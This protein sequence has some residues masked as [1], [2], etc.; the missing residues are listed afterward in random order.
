MRQRGA[1]GL[2]VMPLIDEAGQEAVQ[3]AVTWVAANL[4]V[5]H[6]WLG[7]EGG[8]AASQRALL[9]R[10]RKEELFVSVSEVRSGTQGR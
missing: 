4:A 2:I 8:G 7:R 5:L 9:W 10:P 6:Q 3:V 1:G